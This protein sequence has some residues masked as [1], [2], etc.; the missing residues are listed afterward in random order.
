MTDTLL[1]DMP[2]D[3]LAAPASALCGWTGVISLSLSLSSERKGNTLTFS[4]FLS[5]CVAGRVYYSLPVY[6]LPLPHP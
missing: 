1:W 5:A 6:T 2:G 3:V 4:L